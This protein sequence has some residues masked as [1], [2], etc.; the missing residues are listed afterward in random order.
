MYLAR[1]YIQTHAALSLHALIYDSYQQSYPAT[2]FQVFAIF[3]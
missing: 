2:T 3:F 1:M